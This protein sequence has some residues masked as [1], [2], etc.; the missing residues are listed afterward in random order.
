MVPSE[1]QI[2]QTTTQN[3]HKIDPKKYNAHARNAMAALALEV[4]WHVL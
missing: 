4:F 2:T 1:W 3:I